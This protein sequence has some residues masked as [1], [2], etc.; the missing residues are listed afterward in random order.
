M[1]SPGVTIKM[2]VVIVSCPLASDYVY[3]TDLG[4]LPVNWPKLLGPFENGLPRFSICMFGMSFR[5]T[6]AI[7]K[8]A[9]INIYYTLFDCVYL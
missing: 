2:M 8:K 1:A 6:S 4:N 3:T 7:K 9:D 5:I